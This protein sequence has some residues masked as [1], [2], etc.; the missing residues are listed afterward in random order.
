M[1]L[2]GEQYLEIRKHPIPT[3]GRLISKPKI[4][5]ILTRAKAP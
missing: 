1:I 4:S 3:S 5:G 2:H